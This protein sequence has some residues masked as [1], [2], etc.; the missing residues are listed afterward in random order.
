M[1][2]P[3]IHLATNHLPIILGVT[4]GLA[5]IVGLIW[6]RRA[7]WLYAAVTLA[8][9]GLTVGPVFLLG[10]QAADVV[11]HQPGINDQALDAHEESGEVVVW[12]V[13]AMG[14]VGA[15]AWW[16]LARREEPLSAGLKGALVVAG[17]VT[18]G[19]VAYQARTGGEIVHGEQSLT[20]SGR[21]I[22]APQVVTP[23]AGG[24]EAREG[25]GR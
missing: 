10:D 1:N 18:M 12:V 25:E 3:Y 23:P 8:L 17:L 19:A 22:G 11:E 7:V 14:V 13:L 24:G 9:A 6:N 21:D 4:G 20:G 2:W 5:A 16:R 15:V